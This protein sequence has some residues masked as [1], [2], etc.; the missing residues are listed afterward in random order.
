MPRE[1]EADAVRFAVIR[2]ASEVWSADESP[3]S[4]SVHFVRTLVFDV[5]TGTWSE[6]HPNPILQ[7][8]AECFLESWREKS[9]PVPT[10]LRGTNL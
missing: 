6:G 4:I 5:A 8:Q 1:P 9:R 3:T 7:R 10:S 2:G